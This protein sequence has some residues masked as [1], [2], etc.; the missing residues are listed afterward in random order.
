MTV[1]VYWLVNHDEIHSSGPWD[2][3]LLEQ[4]F[5]GELWPHAFLFDHFRNVK[6]VDD[7]LDHAIIVLPARHHTSDEDLI[8]L[9]EELRKIRASILILVGDEESIFP[10]REVKQAHTQFWV[11]LPDPEAH[12]DMKSWAYFFGDGSP[13]GTTE[14][15]LDK[16]LPLRNLPWSFSGQ[17][18]HKRRKLAVAGMEHCR[19]KGQ[20]V[21]SDGFALG[22]DREHYLDL[23][24]CSKVAPAPAGSFTPDTFRFFEAIEAGA[25]PVVDRNSEIKPGDY[26]PFAFPEA[27]SL[28]F[29][30]VDDWQTAGGFIEQGVRDYPAPQN[31]VQ[32]WWL[33]EKREMVWRLDHDLRKIGATPDFP[34]HFD[35]RTTIVVTA[36]P[37]PS[38]P[39][40]E[41]LRRTIE[42]A[43]ES[44]GCVVP[45]I[46]GFD[47][48]RTEQAAMAKQYEQAIQQVCWDSLHRTDWAGNVLPIISDVHLH[49]AK[50]TARLMDEVRTPT[51]LFME[52]DT[53]FNQDPIDWEACID[54]VAYRSVDVLRFHHEQEILQVHEHL[55]LDEVTKDM[56][57]VPLRRTLQWSARPHLADSDYYRGMLRGPWFRKPNNGFI[58]D[59]MHGVV[60]SQGGH[61][62]A[63][64]HPDGGICRTM[65][66]DGR[67]NGPKFDGRE[68]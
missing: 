46:I 42:S 67:A 4:M 22:L 60:Q 2:T 52:H 6:H 57:G 24:G 58:E 51:I 62:V 28:P 27:G 33:N 19:T 49:Q 31:R 38:H 63:I 66:L 7:N 44:M 55:M 20:V 15:W 23:L 45:V 43:W 40:V 47:G 5:D 26:W 65:H 13:P 64:Y 56:L 10:W 25:L 3:R 61:R 29:P 68:G 34:D 54:L 50:L 17:V 35:Q 30:I 8:W 9:N 14:H 18:T 1:P 21:K 41:M 37:I 59:T 39:S 53:P 36:S 11:Q 48:V 16:P 32:A 12:G